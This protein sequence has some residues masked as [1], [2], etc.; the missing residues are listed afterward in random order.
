M[1]VPRKV[2]SAC[3]KLLTILEFWLSKGHRLAAFF[4]ILAELYAGQKTEDR[5]QRSEVRGQQM[6][7]EK[8]KINWSLVIAHFLSPAFCLLSP[9]FCLLPSVFCLLSPAF[10]LL[11]SAFCLLS[12]VS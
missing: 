2:F 4:S 8:W 11:P 10:C 6:D 1:T 7:N 5:R 12:P 9:A 3:A